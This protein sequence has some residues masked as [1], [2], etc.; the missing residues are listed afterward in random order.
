MFQIRFVLSTFDRVHVK[1]DVSAAVFILSTAVVL[2]CSGVCGRAQAHMS[3]TNVAKPGT[4]Q[5][6]SRPGKITL[7]K[8]VP[9]VRW[10]GTNSV[11]A[12]TMP[13]QAQ[14]TPRIWR[15]PATN[16]IPL[17]QSFPGLRP[18]VYETERY[19]CIVIVPGHTPDDVALIAP[20]VEPRILKQ[21]PELRFKPRAIP[22]R[23]TPPGNSK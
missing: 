22:Q 5:G 4:I 18:G 12:H 9:A 8:P 6:P 15:S 7:F 1:L 19:S 17:R 16:Q 3:R 20:G 13:P 11:V 14:A 23:E 21:I 10:L 2:A